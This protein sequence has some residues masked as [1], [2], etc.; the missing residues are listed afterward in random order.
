[1]AGVVAKLTDTSGT[2]HL[3]SPTAYAQCNTAA[4]TQ[5]KVASFAGNETLSL[6]TN[7]VVWVQFSY[8]NTN[9][10]PQLNIGGSGA[11]VI[12]GI[13]GGGS[14]NTSDNWSPGETVAFRY[15][16]SDWEQLTKNP[17]KVATNADG[18]MPYG[19]YGVMIDDENHP[20][21]VTFQTEDSFY[22]SAGET[23]ATY[24]LSSNNRDISW[25]TSED[26]PPGYYMDNFKILDI[27]SFIYDSNYAEEP[28]VVDTSTKW[29]GGSTGRTV[30]ASI[31]SPIS[32]DILIRITYAVDTYNIQPIQP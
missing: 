8:G 1:M 27:Y 24:N 22:I 29:N 11:K 25:R 19:I 5:I 21:V 3:I 20:Q 31:A 4:A 32:D 2:T 17:I 10:S 28:V 23:T 7:M 26:Q 15:N 18:L 16:G 14:W 13:S 6:V 30:T 12:G 9:A